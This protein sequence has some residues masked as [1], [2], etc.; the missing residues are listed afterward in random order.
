M[1]TTMRTIVMT[2]FGLVVLTLPV[3]G[4]EPPRLAGLWR[5]SAFYAENVDT[6]QRTDIY[7]NRP[8]GYMSIDAEGRYDAWA[9]SHW[10]PNDPSRSG[11][12]SSI[13]DRGAQALRQDGLG[14]RAILYSGRVRTDN[15]LLIVRV[16]QA[17][18]IGFDPDPINVI[19]NEFQTR[20]DDVRVFRLG[21][22]E[23]GNEMLRNE[24]APLADPNDAGNRIVGTVIWVRSSEWDAAPPR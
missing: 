14:Y 24:T 17:T 22:D 20:S 12:P 16:D 19:W 10:P 4:K 21:R 6:K 3:L 7:G 1:R 15:G 2:A 11:Q 13:W 9:L 18:H 5:L 8:I 23:L